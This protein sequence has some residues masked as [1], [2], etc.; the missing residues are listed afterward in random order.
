MNGQ[1]RLLYPLLRMRAGDKYH[2]SRCSLAEPDPRVRRETNPADA[3]KVTKC[4]LRKW[5]K[6]FIVEAC[7]LH[8]GSKVTKIPR[9]VVQNEII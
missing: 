8:T 1:N 9:V 3:D 4:S 2:I 5:S 7:T 6:F